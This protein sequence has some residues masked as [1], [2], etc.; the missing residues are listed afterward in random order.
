MGDG[1]KISYVPLF[2]CRLCKARMFER[3]CIGHLERHGAL[4]IGNWRLVNVDD[5]WRT[6]FVRG[7]KNTPER[8]GALW[9][10]LNHGHTKNTRR[11]AG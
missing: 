5:H 6:Y 4:N 3:D 1:A 10:P 7:R 11:A 9:K 8:P 2:R